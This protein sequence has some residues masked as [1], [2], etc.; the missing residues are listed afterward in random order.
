[1]TIYIVY[2]NTE[3]MGAFKNYESAIKCIAFDQNVPSEEVKIEIERD[4]NYL[5]NYYIDSTELEE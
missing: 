5:D 2:Y 4:G 1:M 3:L